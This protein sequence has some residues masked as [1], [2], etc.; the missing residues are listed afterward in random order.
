MADEKDART[1]MQDQLAD[2][3]DALRRTGAGA[4]EGSIVNQ[5]E[6]AVLDEDGNPV[7]LSEDE[8]ATAGSE[9]QPDAVGRPTAEPEKEEE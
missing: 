3:Q 4:A 8:V 1:E 6:G 5:E 7:E 2:E 9:K